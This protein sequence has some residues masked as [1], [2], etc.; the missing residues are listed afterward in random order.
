[1]LSFIILLEVSPTKYSKIPFKAEQRAAQ[2]LSNRREVSL[3]TVVLSVAQVM[4]Y[5][6]P[7]LGT[8]PVSIQA[9]FISCNHTLLPVM[10]YTHTH[11]H[12]QVHAHTCTHTTH[13]HAHTHTALSRGPA[14]PIHPIS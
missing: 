12:V 13:T 9:G 14:P 7:V 4:R 3:G 5:T 2:H 10:I 8:V 1:M 6:G 11:T